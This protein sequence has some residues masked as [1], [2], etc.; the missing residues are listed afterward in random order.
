MTGTLVDDMLYGFV[1]NL[2]KYEDA[3]GRFHVKGL[4]TD[5]SLDL[6]GQR[7]DPAWLPAAMDGWGEWGNIREMHG[8]N[9]VGTGKH[10]KQGSGY[11]LDTVIIDPLAIE[12]VKNGVYKGFSIGIKG[13]TL[14]KSAQALAMA[15]NGI[16]NG[17]EIIEISLVDRPA[18]P[19]AKIDS[20]GIAK[21]VGGKVEGNI[22]VKEVDIEQIVQTDEAVPCDT[23][24][25][26]GQV[27]NEGG[28][29][30]DFHPC[31]ACD[32][33]GTTGGVDIRPST[34]GG[35]DDEGVVDGDVK[36]AKPDPD[37]KTC[38]GKG[39]IKDGNVKC[40]DC[41]QGKS[42]DLTDYFGY[43]VAE[44]EKFDDTTKAALAELLKK[45]Y[46]TADR[47][48]MA[49][50]GQAMPG[51]GFPIDSV[52]SL[53]NAIQSIGRAKNPDAAKAHIKRRAKALGREDLI[54]DNWKSAIAELVK[55][56]GTIQKG[57]T[58]DTWLHDQA[59]LAAIRDGIIGCITAELAELSSGEMEL[60]DVADLLNV[61]SGFMAWWSNESWGG[62]TAS[63][64]GQGDNMDLTTLGV[65]ADLVKTATAVDA[66]DA[67]RTALAQGLLKALG[68]EDIIALEKS[69][70]DELGKKVTSLESEIEQ[71]KTWAAPREIAIRRTNEQRA[72]ASQVEKLLSDAQSL[73]NSAAMID[74]RADKTQFMNQAVA[75]R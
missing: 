11:W 70:R 37:C 75:L 13:Y 10:A 57:A 60:W 27:L 25:G 42:L 23:C 20:F 2:E 40:P 48:R 21:M 1:G 33:T 47:K 62:E 39:T 4:A 24:S 58:D 30:D 50:S 34:N 66:T 46:S 72:K 67:D 73:E 17:G 64:Y 41:V 74:D 18:N 7:C 12:K 54:P 49:R 61:L 29:T 9:A 35:P 5:A 15:P 44:V 14:D 32:G 31:P 22:L 53:K 28:T 38:K 8:S 19:N 16:I 26:V 43:S 65:S 36:A 71:M 6:D 63:P 59:T 55:K 45:D 68:V 56:F 51:G 3:E 69:A 52:A